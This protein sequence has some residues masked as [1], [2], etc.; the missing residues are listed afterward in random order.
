MIFVLKGDT[1]ESECPSSPAQELETDFPG[2][3]G[4]Q[5]CWGQSSGPRGGLGRWAALLWKFLHRVLGP[6]PAAAERGSG[7]SLPTRAAALA[8][9][10]CAAHGV[11]RVASV[12][13]QGL[14]STGGPSR[15]SRH[16]HAGTRRQRRPDVPEN[17]RASRST[18]TG[19]RPCRQGRVAGDQHAHLKRDSAPGSGRRHEP[20]EPHPRR[21]LQPTRS[22]FKSRLHSENRNW[23][24]GTCSHRKGDVIGHRGPDASSH[25][26][27]RGRRASRCQVPRVVV[28]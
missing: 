22:H 20:P 11:R 10:V 15:W 6:G 8:T 28:N 2:G 14:G 23:T 25:P 17:P 21:W 12:E 3:Q 9:G 5:A 24:R 4:G 7:V 26:R 16:G 13:A 18:G 27:P 19:G 1:V